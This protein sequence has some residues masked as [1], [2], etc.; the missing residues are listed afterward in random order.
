MGWRVRVGVMLGEFHPSPLSH[1]HHLLACWQGR[2]AMMLA[3]EKGRIEIVLLLL[4]EGAAVDFRD[5][6]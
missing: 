2:S 3:A 6:V 5:E 1:R 4:G